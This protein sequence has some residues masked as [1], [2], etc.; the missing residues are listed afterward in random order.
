[1]TECERIALRLWWEREATFPSRVRRAP[2]AWDAITG[3][4]QRIVAQAERVM[5]QETAGRLL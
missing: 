1:M 4:W 2:D 5:A 3:A